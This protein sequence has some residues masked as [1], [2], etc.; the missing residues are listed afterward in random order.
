MKYVYRDPARL[1]RYPVHVPEETPEPTPAV[2]P[3]DPPPTPQPPKRRN[4]YVPPPKKKPRPLPPPLWG[5][6]LGLQLAAAE[7]L[8]WERRNPYYHHAPKGSS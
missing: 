7:A 6:T 4:V 8:D 1:R 5:G 2:V 3:A